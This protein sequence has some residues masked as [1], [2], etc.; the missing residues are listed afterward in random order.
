MRWH[1]KFILSALVWISCTA[2]TPSEAPA[3]P[4]PP[5]SPTAIIPLQPGEAPTATTV[6]FPPTPTYTPLPNVTLG[7]RATPDPGKRSGERILVDEFDHPEF[8]TTGKTSAGSIAFG[9]SELSLGVAQPEGYL[10]SLRSEP[11]LADFYL[12]ITA[13]PSICRDQDEYGVVFH[14]TPTLDLYR[15]GLNCDG[16]ARLERALSGSTTSS[17]EPQVYGVIP[18][19]APSSTRIG[20]W[21][22]SK[23]MR[24][25]ANGEF[26]FTVEDASIPEGGLGVF[27][28]AAGPAA[29]TV[30]FSE[31]EI[32]EARP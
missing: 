23:E 1:L 20:I 29:M 4:S 25:F 19:G 10:Q 14:V 7:A 22:T 16:E 27:A 31:L 8:W 3:V 28:H 21:S 9:I 6:W 30:N 17:Q 15:F 2:C 32:F 24:F 18:P 12:E 26:L 13:S 11:I 5:G